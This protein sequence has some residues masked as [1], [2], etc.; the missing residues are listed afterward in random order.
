[1]AF[2][3]VVATLPFVARARPL[4]IEPVLRVIAPFLP[5]IVPIKGEYRYNFT[6]KQPSSL[7][8]YRI[9][10]TDNDGRKTQSRIIQIS[11]S[12]V[13]KVRHY[14][15]G[16]FIFIET[17]NTEVG[18]GTIELYNIEGKLMSTQKVILDKSDNTYKIEKPI[19]SGLYLLRVT[20]QGENNY[21]G[22]VMV[23]QDW[24]LQVV[25]CVK[26][27]RFV[28]DSVTKFFISA[29]TFAHLENDFQG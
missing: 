20:G 4:S 21:V 1:M 12:K 16:S 3:N 27:V 26:H 18:N 7:A 19:Q 22:K 6:D 24:F 25:K 29:H 9:E 14:T 28:R 2:T 17:N 10:Q 23:A 13:F 5:R 11:S 15:Q 8:Y